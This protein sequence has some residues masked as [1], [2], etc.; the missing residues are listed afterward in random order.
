MQLFIQQANTHYRS[1]MGQN[2]PGAEERQ[3]IEQKEAEA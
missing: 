2:L 3:L 1:S